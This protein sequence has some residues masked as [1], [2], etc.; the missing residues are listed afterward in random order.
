MTNGNTQKQGDFKLKPCRSSFP[1]AEIYVKHRTQVHSPGD[2]YPHQRSPASMSQLPSEGSAP[3]R[4][5][6]MAAPTTSWIKV[7]EESDFSIQNIPFGVISTAEDVTP[8]IATIVGDTVVDLRA[9]A[10]AGLFP[11]SYAATLSESTLNAFMAAGRP[12]WRDARQ[13][14]QALLAGSEFHDA[15]AALKDNAALCAT[16]LI[17]VS[18][19]VPHL[20]AAIGDYT[21]FYSSREHATNVG[22]MFRG[23]A[24]ALQPNW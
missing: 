7:P 2:R 10:R 22:V 23:V 9:L 8:R 3:K 13:R 6:T 20:P 18:T 5:R 15:D 12:V 4:V 1:P 24:N 16:A 19:I 21:D 14:I 17:P 11:A